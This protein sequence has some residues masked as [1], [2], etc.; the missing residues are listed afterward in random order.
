MR[1]ARVAVASGTPTGALRLPTA[2]L[3]VRAN[4]TAL[5]RTIGSAGGHARSATCVLVSASRQVVSPASK[6]AVAAVD[7]VRVNRSLRSAAGQVVHHTRQGELARGTSRLAQRPSRRRM[8]SDALGARA[9]RPSTR[10]GPLGERNARMSM[11][12]CRVHHPVNSRRPSSRLCAVAPTARLYGPHADLDVCSTLPSSLKHGP[13]DKRSSPLD[14]A[15]T[16]LDT[17]LT[18]LDT[19][20][21]PL[22]TSLTPL[23]TF[24][25]PATCAMAG[26]RF[27]ADRVRACGCSLVIASKCAERGNRSRAIH[28]L[29]R[30]GARNARSQFS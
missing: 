13:L 7:C 26:P 5:R 15:L 30:H 12:T 11:R 4:S 16:R 2:C 27:V 18:R 8:R 3:D 10:Y 25:T 24:P 22:D 14:I 9:T 23:G 17:S 28:L 20:L 19:S 1:S 21:T 29:V 6:P